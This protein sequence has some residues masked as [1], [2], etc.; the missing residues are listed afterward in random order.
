MFTD[1]I[2]KLH[3]TMYGL[4]YASDNMKKKLIDIGLIYVV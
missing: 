2:N 3:E 4:K 1:Q